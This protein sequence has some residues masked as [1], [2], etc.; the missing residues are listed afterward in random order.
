MANLDNDANAQFR[1]PT[2]F[3][4]QWSLIVLVAFTI[5]DHFCLG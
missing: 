5:M 3:N 1:R 4:F 2:Q